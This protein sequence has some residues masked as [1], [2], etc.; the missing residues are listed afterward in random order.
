RTRM[1]GS[2]AA[3]PAGDESASGPKGRRDKASCTGASPSSTMLVA[4]PPGSWTTR[5]FSTSSICSRGTD[6]CTKGWSSTPT[7]RSIWASPPEDSTKE[8]M[9]SPPW[10]ARAPPL[11]TVTDAARIVITGLNT[12]A[13]RIPGLLEHAR[14]G[15]IHNR[16]RRQVRIAA[17][18]TTGFKICAENAPLWHAPLQHLLRALHVC[19][20]EHTA[21]VGKILEAES[22]RRIGNTQEP[23]LFERLAAGAQ[24][25][26]PQPAHGRSAFRGKQAQQGAARHIGF[27]GN[28]RHVE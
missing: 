6:N 11:H 3:S 4:W 5:L 20:L 19:R 14:A 10:A 9:R 22:H 16:P 21:V 18:G 7:W 8:V 2:A 17:P 23:S 25:F 26:R 28:G 1:P 13:K 24:P 12:V 15:M 27:A